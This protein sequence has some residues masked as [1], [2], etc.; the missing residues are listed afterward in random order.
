MLRNKLTSYRYVGQ[1]VMREWIIKDL[2]FGSTIPSIVVN[3]LI[4]MGC[5]KVVNQLLAKF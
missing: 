5:G 3:S 1:I 4:A 2:V